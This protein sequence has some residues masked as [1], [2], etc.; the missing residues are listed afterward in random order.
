MYRLKLKI[1][2]K[3]Y[4]QAERDIEKNIIIKCKRL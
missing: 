3:N 4:F 1:I 2:E